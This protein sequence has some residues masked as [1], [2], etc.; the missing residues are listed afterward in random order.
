M[1]RRI[2][3]VA[4]LSDLSDASSAT[5]QPVLR[6][7]EVSRSY[8]S[9][10]TAVRAL[11]SVSFALERTEVAA[12]VGPS[13]S[14]KTTLLQMAGAIDH[15]TTGRVLHNGQD[16]A[17]LNAR[18]LTTL[19]RRHIG[20]VFQLFNL[21]PGLN[22]EDNVALV[23]RLDGTTRANARER[24]RE[25]LTQ[26]G[27]AHRGQHLPSQLSGGEQQRVA[28]A[29]AL[30]NNPRLILADEPTGS[31]DRAAGRSVIDLLLQ[32]A[33]HNGTSVLIVTHDMSLI[34]DAHHTFVMTDG[35]LLHREASHTALASTARCAP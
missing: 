23:A 24:A 6:L 30:M 20:F 5:E 9:G 29:R 16:L 7:D 3:T 18:E 19:R 11:D 4:Q 15:P 34:S 31:L 1:W 26:V 35:R 32:T 27:L 2:R 14:G 28:I 25:M 10:D 13:G 17:M 22:A 12:L 8:G 21:V 33:L